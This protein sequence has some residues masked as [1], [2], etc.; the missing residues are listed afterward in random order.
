MIRSNWKFADWLLKY[1]TPHN[2]DQNSGEL[3]TTNFMRPSNARESPPNNGDQCQQSYEYLR[4]GGK[5][6]PNW[7]NISQ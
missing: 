3:G 5:Q 4:Y 1:D 7:K 2:L 6:T